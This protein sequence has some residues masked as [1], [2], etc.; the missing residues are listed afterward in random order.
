M[1]KPVEIED[2]EEMRRHV[3]IVDVE[4]RKAIRGLQIGD[5]VKLTFLAGPGGAAGET[6]SVRITRING[7]E[8]R[9]QLADTPTSPRLTGLRIGSGVKFTTAHIHSLPDSRVAEEE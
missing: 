4:L 5:H 2:I 3:G 6:L 7:S 8:F 9:G 1:R